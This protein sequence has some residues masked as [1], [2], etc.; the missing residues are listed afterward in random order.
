MRLLLFQFQL[1]I[2]VMPTRRDYSGWLPLLVAAS[3]AIFLLS[4][5]S[6][7]PEAIDA[8]VRAMGP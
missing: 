6:L 7:P 4:M 3:A 2:I 1:Y 8:I 5:L